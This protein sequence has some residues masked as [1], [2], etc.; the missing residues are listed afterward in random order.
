L[1]TSPG[2][3]NKANVPLPAGYERCIELTKGFDRA[4]PESENSSNSKLSTTTNSWLLMAFFIV[5]MMYTNQP[6]QYLSA[7]YY[8]FIPLLAVD[9]TGYMFYKGILLQRKSFVDLLYSIYY[10][11]DPMIDPYRAE[12]EKVLATLL[13]RKPGALFTRPSK[14]S[15]LIVFTTHRCFHFITSSDTSIER[16]LKMPSLI[17]IE[18]CDYAYAPDFLPLD[19]SRNLS[20]KW[21]AKKFSIR[22]NI[23][24]DPETWELM[25]IDSINYNLLEAILTKRDR[26]G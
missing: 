12:N 16:A 5:F 20:G 15:G 11:V 17:G 7:L 9:L 14:P 6:E 25:P 24:S 23:S 26:I 10:K 22:T 8:F 2:E 4:I 3:I 18:V 1:N 13:T 21:I 19:L